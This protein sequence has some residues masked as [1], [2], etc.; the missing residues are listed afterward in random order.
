MEQQIVQKLKL[1]HGLYSDGHS[2]QPSNEAIFTDDGGLDII[3]YKGEPL[4][5]TNINDPNSPTNLFGFNND[6]GFNSHL[7]PSDAC[8]NF[9]I[10]EFS[11]KGYKGELIETFSKCSNDDDEKLPLSC[12]VFARKVL[13]GGK[14]FIKNSN[15]ASTK[16]IDTLQSHLTGIY[17]SVKYNKENPFSYI[18]WCHLPIVET[19]NGQ[20]IKSQQDLIEWMSN[21]YH[22]NMF[23]IISYNDIIPVQKLRPNTIPKELQPGVA[24]FGKKLS[25]R[26]WAEHAYLFLQLQGLTFNKIY[27]NYEVGISKKISVKFIDIPV[28]N[29]I[30]K[31]YLKLLK[32]ATNLEQFF[33]TNN[34]VPVKDARS[35][36]FIKKYLICNLG[37]KDQVRLVVKC[38]RYEILINK[39]HIKLAKGFEE[40]IDKAI[41]SIEPYKS[42]QDTFD[43][44]GHLFPQRIVLGR[45][46]HSGIPNISSDTFDEINLES[47]DSESLKTHLDH[48]NVSYLL[49]QG[50][51]IIDVEDVDEISNRIQDTYSDLEIIEYDQIIP[52]FDLLRI[53][54]R[55]FKELDE[56]LSMQHELKILMTGITDLKD[57]DNSNTE[58]FKRVNIE[59][60]LKSRNYEVYG[61][62][63]SGDV[64]LE[65]CCINFGMY[66]FN[67]FSAIIKTSHVTYN[68]ISECRMLWMII[69]IPSELSVFSPNN[70]DFK[71]DFIK[72]PIIIKP[73]RSYFCKINTKIELG[74]GDRIFINSDHSTTNYGPNNIIKLAGWESHS[75]DVQVINFN[76][77]RSRLFQ[78]DLI[79]CIIYYHVRLLFIDNKAERYPLKSI[80]YTTTRENC[81]PDIVVKK[82][83][84]TLDKD[85]DD[86][87][88]IASMDIGTTYSGYGYA[89]R[90]NN[91]I[92]INEIWPDRSKSPK[93][94]IDTLSLHNVCDY[95][96]TS[97]VY[98]KCD[99]ITTLWS[100]FYN[101][102]G[103]VKS[104]LNPEM[105]FKILLS[106]PSKCSYRI[107]DVIHNM[108]FEEGTIQTIS[109]SEAAAIHC[110][111]VIRR[112][113]LLVEPMSHFLVVNCGGA[114]VELTMR[115]LLPNNKLAE[116]SLGTC[117]F[118]GSIYVDR[119]FFVYI[120]I[121]VG[122]DA[123]NS[124]RTKHHEQLQLLIQ[125]CQEIKHSFTGNMD[126]YNT[127]EIN[128]EEICPDIK[129]YVVGTYKDEM[130]KDDWIIKFHYD[131]IK[132]MFDP[133]IK[134]IILLI[135]QQLSFNK[136][137]VIIFLVGGF[138]ESKYLQK[139]IKQEFQHLVSNIF[140]PNQPITAVLRGA[141][142][143]ALNPNSISTRVINMTYGIKQDGV[144]KRIVKIG[145]EAHENQEFG[146][147]LSLTHEDRLRFPIELYST[148]LRNPKFCEDY[149]VELIAN[150]KISAPKSWYSK[151]YLVLI[152]DQSEIRVYVKN[153][154]GRYI[155]AG[156]D[157]FNN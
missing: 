50:G 12:Q 72:T 154:Y 124:L 132:K 145:T 19:S 86:F 41:N 71:V 82:K 119:K 32:P 62:I 15:L 57:L 148:N 44:F 78:L 28:I 98:S 6:V 95:D 64:K 51:D 29:T 5:Y 91:E 146:L 87:Q 68:R 150:I 123:L 94:D 118:C 156:L 140:V 34:I 96:F 52:T 125:R 107:K 85:Y 53:K 21:L 48:L 121:K 112:G 4:V 135:H 114:T 37:N 61:S 153:Q 38:E 131:H 100:C 101:L 110:M 84:P 18:E 155:T 97:A 10:A 115:Q 73:E 66:D 113:N 36:P 144:F 134:R 139:C 90:T 109:E 127:C 63:L 13:V 130:E 128:L 76:Y 2:I 9:P 129:Q 83:I 8:I 7:Q 70:R 24:N 138:S 142:E 35:F 27:K 81:N 45:S 47:F 137:C 49:T 157:Y 60:S 133:I 103:L 26:R 39:A 22:K 89:N 40:S 105:D 31:S 23:D 14:L 108:S 99:N 122:P 93:T 58:H 55:H 104:T 152:F 16:Q 20:V 59:P 79:I 11:Y 42:L 46:F 3:L 33:I 69:G 126:D 56:L 17:N 141:L 74:E 1:N 136:S 54:Y 102:F 111:N 149:G 43:E 30:K 75:F 77:D 117:G 147:E 80:G 92:I 25:F 116:K 151:L 67:G 88:M 120:S 65:N 143:Y 106:V